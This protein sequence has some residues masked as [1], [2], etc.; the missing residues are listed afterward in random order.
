MFRKI[1]AKFNKYK[2]SSTASSFMLA[3]TQGMVALIF[4]LVD[5]IF[6]KKMDMVSFGVW[7]QMYYIIGLLV[8]ILSL[9]IPEGFKYYI[10][11]EKEGDRYFSNA[12]MV[13]FTMTCI[14][15]FLLLIINA[16]AFFRLVDLRE[17]YL[18]SLLFP[19]CFLVFNWNR[20]FR[21][22][23]INENRVLL[24]TKVL[25]IFFVPTLL[26]VLLLGYYFPYVSKQYLW[27]GILIYVLIYG[28]P[29]FTLFYKSTFN[30]KLS[31]IKWESISQ[32]LKIGLPLYLATFIGVLTVNLD[33]GIVSIFEDKVTF[34]VFSVG[35]IEIPIFAM[36][37]AAFSQQIYPRLVR[38]VSNNEKEAAKALWIKTTVKVSYITYPMILLLMIFAKPLLFFIYS[39][40]YADS[41]T[42]FQTYLLVA[43]LR[44]N[45]YGALITASGATRYITYYSVASLLLNTIFATVLYLLI[46]IN[47]IV[48][49][50]LLSASVIA[51]LQLKHEGLLK[52]Y[53]Y[54]FV[55]DKKI[56]LL[57]VSILIAFFIF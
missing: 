6:S 10:A 19:L 20:L 7:K 3:F 11:R 32:M 46:G 40:E 56:I 43:L 57:I 30:F 17:Y 14:G 50:T 37:S 26:A 38:M 31:L 18:V 47:G 22:A 51:F 8:P 27:V 33:K 13:S 55:L 39:E 48:Y 44:N 49:G 41:V 34:A 28:S 2:E 25:S 29:L 5:Y 45:Y 52:S 1:L 16:L 9:G 15:A 35:A 24:N 21:Y 53:L 42:I 4:I 36:L 23:N 12:I 54:T